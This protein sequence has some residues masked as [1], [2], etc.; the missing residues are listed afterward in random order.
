MK[1]PKILLIHFTR[2]LRFHLIINYLQLQL[3]FATFECAF[4]W[5]S[6]L[7]DHW[8]LL[9]PLK[10]TTTKQQKNI[11]QKLLYILLPVA[12]F[13]LANQSV[14]NDRFSISF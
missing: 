14:N 13:E 7:C 1:A 11:K 2:W 9:P 12:C 10:K 6:E 8:E 5:Y 4:L 3:Y